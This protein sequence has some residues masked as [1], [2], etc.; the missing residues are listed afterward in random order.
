VKVVAAEAH[1]SDALYWTMLANR[2]KRGEGLLPPGMALVYHEEVDTNIVHL[3][4]PT[5]RCLSLGAAW[6]APKV[7]HRALGWVGG[8]SCVSVPD[9]LPMSAVYKF[10]STSAAFS[11]EPS[12]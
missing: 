4:R 11:S 5:S 12:I 2:D 8:V 9:E 3:D 7:V 1:G 10:A 6:P